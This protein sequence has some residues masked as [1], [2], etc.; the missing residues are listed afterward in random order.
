MK[1]KNISEYNNLDVGK[2]IEVFGRAVKR[3]RYKGF[4][5]L[6]LSIPEGNIMTLIDDAQK[7]EKIKMGSIVNVR[8]QTYLSREDKIGLKCKEYRIITEPNSFRHEDQNLKSIIRDRVLLE[9]TVRDYFLEK[10]LYEIDSKVLLDYRGSPDTPHFETKT[11][12]NEPKILRT[13]LELLL[14]RCVYRTQLPVFEIGHVFRDLVVQRNSLNEYA[15]LEAQIPYE[16]LDYGLNILLDVLKKIEDAFNAPKKLS[17]RKNLDLRKLVDV[18]SYNSDREVDN[19][20][21]N[22]RDSQKEPTL[23]SYIPSVVTPL[24]K[25]L[26]NDYA[27]KIKYVSGIGE[28]CEVYEPEINYETILSLFEEQSLIMKEKGIETQMDMDFIKDCEM[29]IVPTLGVYLGLDRLL[30]LLNERDIR[31]FYI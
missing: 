12:E 8:G 16:D 27:K 24:T 29:G 2:E 23:L 17:P 21:K 7:K 28:I 5:V 31:E 10:D 1:I 18:K 14:R 19:A 26:S 9:K 25:R 22:I 15:V 3:R 4:T 20:Y 30:M 6:E 13:T 11:W